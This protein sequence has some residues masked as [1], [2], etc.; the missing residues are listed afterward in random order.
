MAGQ[1]FW[2]STNT[3]PKRTHRFILSLGNIGS[4]QGI[5]EF[6]VQSVKRPSFTRSNVE[7]HF[8][9]KIF[10][11]PGKTNWEDV[12][13]T[14]VDA[15]SPNGAQVLFDIL[16]RSGYVV[17]SQITPA[18]QRQELVTVSKRRSMLALG[19]PIVKGLSSEGDVLEEWSLKQAWISAVDFGEYNYESDDK[20]MINITIVYDWAELRAT[21]IP[22]RQVPL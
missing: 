11:Y 5:S 2:T 16:R 8:L 6:V 9:D 15:V 13:C 18:L 4:Q 20:L 10:K 1:N 14:I 12:S 3:E 22:L 21:G 17:P 7:Y 19:T